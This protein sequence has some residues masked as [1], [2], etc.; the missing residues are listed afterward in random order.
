MSK[1][2][3]IVILFGVIYLGNEL[4]VE[5]KL[6]LEEYK[7]GFD[8]YYRSETL[9]STW[10]NFFMVAEGIIVA[11]TAQLLLSNVRILWLVAFLVGFFGM[12][13]SFFWFLIQARN[14][15]FS[16]S[17]G[18]RLREVENLLSR[19][20]E[21]NK[22]DMVFTFI[23]RHRQIL[24]ERTVNW[25]EKQPTWRLRKIIPVFFVAIWLAISII[26]SLRFF[27]VL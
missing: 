19:S 13:I 20:F 6:L 16:E 15:R 21:G 5:E 26:S 9:Y 7:I 12:I 10:E 4:T 27:K 8:A 17:R 24:D 11:V 14:Y 23:K 2:R 1:I 22:K 3:T 25:Y 18:A